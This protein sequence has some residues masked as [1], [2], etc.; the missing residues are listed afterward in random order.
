[1]FQ[2]ENEVIEYVNENDVK[3]VRLA[4]CDIFGTQKN[5]SIMAL[6]L[7]RAFNIGI[8]FDASA[9]MGFGMEEKSDL[10]LFPDP[11]TFSVLPW[12]PAHGRVV[13]LFCDIRYPDGR[14]FELDGRQLLKN[15]VA[16]V[17][18]AG[19]NCYM[20][21][22]CE[23]YLFKTGEK[24]EATNEPFDNG[25]YMDIMPADKGENVRREICM[26]LEE[27]GIMVE[28]SHHE[29]GPGQNE[30]DF[31][32]SEALSSADNVTTYKSVVRTIAE[33]NG[34]YASFDPKPLKNYAG[35]GMHINMS[36]RRL[37]ENFMCEDIETNFMAGIME[38][39]VEMTAFLNPAFQSYERL[40][41][42]KAP[43]YVT[44]SHENR[45]QL[46]RIPA[47][48]GEYNRIELRSPDCLTNPYI[49]YTLLIEAGLD[50][51]KR[52]LEPMAP[53]D[54]NLYTAPKDVLAAYKKLP[55]NFSEAITVAGK[56]NFIR[57]VISSNIISAYKDR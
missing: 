42:F 17:R 26:T 14:P 54:I 38:H 35:N 39:I 8:S 47:A 27:M 33:R 44:W 21:A 56:S 23:F 53:V 13:R 22:E 43:S 41:A 32:Y 55:E 9:I 40:G 19:Y 20:G 37:G 3:F 5:I 7:H 51:V 15:T 31:K 25:G 11:S 29:E 18:N 1:M 48:V 4:F 45:S 12:R 52:R 6:E 28:S 46:V 10:F 16:K 30:I 24:G 2:T 34:L 57:S 50:G 49:A 36:I